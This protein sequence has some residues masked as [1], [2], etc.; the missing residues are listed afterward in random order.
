MRARARR[1]PVT[2][3]GQ[4]RAQDAAGRSNSCQGRRRGTWD[5]RITGAGGLTPRLRRRRGSGRGC[6]VS[7]SV[8][9]VAGLTAALPA[10]WPRH[11]WLAAHRR[12]SA[13]PPD[14]EPPYPAR[15]AQADSRP[16]Q[17]TKP[18]TRAGTGRYPQPTNRPSCD[19]EWQRGIADSGRRDPRHPTPTP[20]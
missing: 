17:L 11:Q 18:A 2:G 5:T 20:L 12:L 3:A 13:L 10:R 14:A 15:F 4:V 1:S 16:G 19:Q 6:A 7:A 8:W 9:T